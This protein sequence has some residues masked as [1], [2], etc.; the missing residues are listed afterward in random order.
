MKSTL[1]K[2]NQEY[3]D[4]SDDEDDPY[5]KAVGTHDFFYVIVGLSILVLVWWQERRGRP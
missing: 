3:D 4:E 1:S 2:T 5:G